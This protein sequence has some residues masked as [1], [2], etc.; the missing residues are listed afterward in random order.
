M[1]G[2]SRQQNQSDRR[3]QRDEDADEDLMQDGAGAG[4]REVDDRGQHD[5]PDTPARPE[6][7]GVDAFVERWQA[8]KADRA[9]QRESRADQQQARDEDDNPD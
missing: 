6:R 7:R 3:G 2:S 1:Q 9:E 4:D 5:C 8:Q